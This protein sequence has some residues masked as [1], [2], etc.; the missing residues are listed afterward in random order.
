MKMLNWMKQIACS[1]MLPSG[2]KRKQPSSCSNRSMLHCLH[3]NSDESSFSTIFNTF[4]TLKALGVY[5][6]PLKGCPNTIQSAVVDICSHRR[7]KMSTLTAQVAALLD[8]NLTLDALDDDSTTMVEKA[9][10]LAISMQIISAD[11]GYAFH[12]VLQKYAT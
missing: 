5:S 8:Q 7:T 4:A 9:V 10:E 3:L 6:K 1:V 11:D 2:T 12:K